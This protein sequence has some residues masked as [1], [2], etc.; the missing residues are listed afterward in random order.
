M[1]LVSEKAFSRLQFLEAVPI[2]KELYAAKFLAR[3][4]EARRQYKE[5]VASGVSLRSIQMYEQRKNDIDKAQGQTLYKLA[6]TLGCT[7]EDLLE[8]PAK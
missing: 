6:A 7:I 1:G 4:K 8:S 5:E 2:E 3:D